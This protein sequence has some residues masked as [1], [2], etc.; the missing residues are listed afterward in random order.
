MEVLESV[1]AIEN[2]NLVNL[3]NNNNTL[4]LSQTTFNCYYL[5]IIIVS[6]VYPNCLLKSLPH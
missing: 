2:N 3:N 5:K 6:S 1:K 4:I